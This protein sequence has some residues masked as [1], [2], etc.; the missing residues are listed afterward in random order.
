MNSWCYDIILNRDKYIVTYTK[1]WELLN[2]YVNVYV[3][4]ILP[5]NNCLLVDV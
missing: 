3:Y 4:A 1:E 2:V 5:T